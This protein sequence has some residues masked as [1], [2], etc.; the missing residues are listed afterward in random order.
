[1][2]A[3][4]KWTRYIH[5]VQKS[6]FELAN[7]DNSDYINQVLT[8]SVDPLS[9]AQCIFYFYHYKNSWVYVKLIEKWKK[10]WGNI[11]WAPT[12]F[13]NSFTQLDKSMFQSW[14]MKLEIC[15]KWSM[16]FLTK[17]KIIQLLYV[18]KDNGVNR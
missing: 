11:N 3:I 5:S 16:I 17:I 7:L 15:F 6:S 8:L 1:M 18:I 13:S 14:R 9:S 12:L 2:I 10:N 4:S